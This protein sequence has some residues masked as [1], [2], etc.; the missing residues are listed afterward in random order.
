MLILATLWLG[1]LAPLSGQPAPVATPVVAATET[2]VPE[3]GLSEQVESLVGEE[4]EEEAGPPTARDT[5]RPALFNSMV[6]QR[7]HERAGTS[8]RQIQRD[9]RIPWLISLV[10]LPIY[11]LLARRRGFSGSQEDR[12]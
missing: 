9:A 10:L 11:L 5:T 1:L 3:Q 7:L 2:P 8:I 4:E 12:P 6:A